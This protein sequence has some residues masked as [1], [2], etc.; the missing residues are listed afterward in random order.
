MPKEMEINAF[1]E[2]YRTLNFTKAAENLF[3]SQ[4][5]CSKYVRNLER[6]VGFPLFERS[7]RKVIPTPEGD[8]LFQMLNDAIHSYREVIQIGRA[9]AGLEAVPLRV[10][11]MTMTDTTFLA[12]RYRRFMNA[13]PHVTITWIY[14]DPEKLKELLASDTIDLAIMHTHLDDSDN[15]YANN[16]DYQTIQLCKSKMYL[17]YSKHHPL[18]KTA[19]T[20]TDFEPAIVSA[21]HHDCANTQADIF[22]V[23]RRLERFGLRNS[24]IRL[25]DSIQEAD[26]SVQLGETIALASE[27][28]AFIHNPNIEVMC[29]GEGAPMVCIWKRNNSNAFI[30]AFV[31]TLTGKTEEL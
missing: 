7:T 12:D 14:K 29:L 6:E 4:Q 20:P 19:K 23:R 31:D 1:C 15:T 26:A 18:A 13:H 3:L 5:A 24:V 10:G 27:H 2:V 17:K 16:P 25:Y 30:R 8:M 21:F 28:N 9:H 11:I 22:Q